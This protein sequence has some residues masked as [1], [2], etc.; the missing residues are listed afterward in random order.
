MTTLHPHFVTDPDG[1][2]LSVVLPLAEYEAL[3]AQLEDLEDALAADAAYARYLR[4]EEQALSLKDVE[5]DLGLA[6]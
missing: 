2:R 4:G 1:K 6:G 5:R 3:L